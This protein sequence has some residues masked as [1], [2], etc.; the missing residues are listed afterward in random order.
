M[1]QIIPIKDLKDTASVSELCHKADEPI[2]ITKNGYGDMVLMSMELFE[3]TRRKLDMYND[4]LISE[5][6]IKAGKTKDARKALAEVKEK[7]GL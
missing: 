6:Q 2:F 7:Y 4:L 1:P 5:E 3:S